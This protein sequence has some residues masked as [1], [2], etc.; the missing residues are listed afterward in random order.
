MIGST[1]NQSGRDDTRRSGDM[2]Q[3]QEERSYHEKLTEKEHEVRKLTRKL[4]AMQEQVM[5]LE[6]SLQSQDGR[7]IKKSIDDG[8]IYES[9][10][11]KDV[12]VDSHK[13]NSYVIDMEEGRRQETVQIPESF[14]APIPLVK[15][16]QL[17]PAKSAAT[18]TIKNAEIS[19][20]NSDDFDELSS[21]DIE[22]LIDNEIDEECNGAS[23]HLGGSK[24]YW[25]DIILGVND[26]ICSTFLLIAGVAGGGLSSKDIL[27]TAIAGSIAGAVSMCAGEF[28]ATKSQ[29]EV[30]HGEIA[31]EEE[32]IRDHRRAELSEVSGLLELIGISKE[33][34]DLQ[35]CIVKHYASDPDA[36][37]KVMIALQLGF[38]EEEQRS[39]MMAGAVSFFLFLLGAIPSVLPYTIPGIDPTTGLIAAAVATGFTLLIVGAVKTWA[40]KGNCFSAALEN[41]TIAGFGG[42]FAYVVG[43]IFDRFVHA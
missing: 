15:E 32:H 8:T 7:R 26:G 34:R 13:G 36:L 42:A 20:T 17:T 2:A 37:L 29:N 33:N 25:R 38:L 16:E 19:G 5:A 23:E 11:V 31:L 1:G 41:V 30:M 18:T 28:T 43:L 21:M 3:N 10:E 4:E 35:K 12:D 22:W 24:Q 6:S 40:T 14:E 27:L 39:P 9:D